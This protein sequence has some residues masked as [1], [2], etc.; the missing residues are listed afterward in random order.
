MKRLNLIILIILALIITVSL[1]ACNSADKKTPKMWCMEEAEK[2]MFAEN[3]ELYNIEY[4]GY[5]V[6]DIAIANVVELDDYPF[7]AYSITFYFDGI[8]KTYLTTIYYTE[9]AWDNLFD[10]TNRTGIKKENILDLDIMEDNK[11]ENAKTTAEK[12]ILDGYSEIVKLTTQIMKDTAGNG[13]IAF[14]IEAEGN[15]DSIHNLF[16]VEVKK[17]KAEL[18]AQ[19]F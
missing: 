3:T 1:F 11:I 15:T 8:T 4:I 10:R 19:L 7:N 12:F 5:I 18:I 14:M 13:R 16:I 17:D 9:T 2:E 6:E